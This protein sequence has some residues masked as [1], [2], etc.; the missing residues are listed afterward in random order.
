MVQATPLH[1]ASENGHL[2][3][4]RYLVGQGASCTVT[5]LAGVGMRNSSRK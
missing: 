5:D 2:W 3:L 1:L 4:V